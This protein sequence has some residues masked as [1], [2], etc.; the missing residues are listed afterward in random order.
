VTG[1]SRSGSTLLLEG[2][3]ESRVTA[4]TS[5]TVKVKQA[6]HRDAF[7]MDR[8]FAQPDDEGESDAVHRR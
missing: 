3:A 5:S 8:R 1:D 2:G 6:V 7:G 4:D